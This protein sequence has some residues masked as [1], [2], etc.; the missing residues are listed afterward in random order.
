MIK[1]KKYQQHIYG[2]FP[3][4]KTPRIYKTPKIIYYFSTNTSGNFFR[5]ISAPLPHDSSTFL[6]DNLLGKAPAGIYL[7]ISLTWTSFFIFVIDICIPVSKDYVEVRN[8]RSHFG[9]LKS[10]YPSYS[11]SLQ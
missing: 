11:G 9:L 4:M 1:N 10:R 5:T 3:I 6:L 7:P 2:G 8:K